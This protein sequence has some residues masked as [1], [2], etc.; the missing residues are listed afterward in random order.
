MGG[1]SSSGSLEKKN[2]MRIKNRTKLLR[3]PPEVLK[4]PE[5]GIRVEDTKR[6]GLAGGMSQRV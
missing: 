4:T 5:S 2:E 6:E 3:N 1:S